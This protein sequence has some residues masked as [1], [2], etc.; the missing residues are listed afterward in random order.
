MIDVASNVARY[1]GERSPVERAS[2]FDYCFNYFQSFND[3][4]AA[5][6]LTVA[7]Q[8][9]ASCLHLGYYLASWGM[10]R[11]STTLHSKSY[12]Y[13]EPAVEAIATE[14]ATTWHIDAD[15]YT[16]E[17]IGALLATRDRLAAALSPKPNTDG[18][19]R[20]ATNTL[21]TKVMLGVFGS[22]PAF[23]TFFVRGFR[24]ETDRGVSFGRSALVGVADFYQRHQVAVDA[25][26]V[27]TL[28]A[29]T[30]RPTVR[31]YTKAKIIDMALLIEGGGR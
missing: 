3:R 19:A 26:T 12:R 28:D 7:N 20:M 6:E 29:T 30:G 23:D 25:V 11:G 4:D 24:D 13:F 5:D 9:E 21:V 10:L 27:Y 8:L 18:Q 1:L 15:S 17:N 16:E 22:V 31:P 14:P 2:S